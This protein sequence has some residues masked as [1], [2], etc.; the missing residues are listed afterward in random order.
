MAKRLIEFNVA[1]LLCFAPLASVADYM[2]LPAA[3][4]E[5]MVTGITEVTVLVR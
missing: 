5:P 1:L 2:K 3:E 4:K